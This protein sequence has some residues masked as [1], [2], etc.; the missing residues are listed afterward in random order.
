MI[1][2]EWYA[3]WRAGNSK[4]KEQRYLTVN[5]AAGRKQATKVFLIC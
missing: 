1:E 3:R 4:G 2:G 5:L